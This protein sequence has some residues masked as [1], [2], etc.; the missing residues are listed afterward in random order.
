MKRIVQSLVFLVGFASI[1]GFNAFKKTSPT[2]AIPTVFAIK[3][4]LKVEIKVS[5]ELEAA[6]SISIASTIKGDQGKI[7]DL[8]VDGVY[9]QP[10]QVL[11][12]M[13]PT[14]F[15]DKVEKLLTQLKE[16][17]AYIAALEQT[18][19]WEKSQAEHKNRTAIYEIETATLELDKIIYGDGPQ[20]ISRLKGA[21]QKAWLKYD[22][23]NAYSNDLMELE[24]QGFLNTTEIRQAQK[25]LAEEREVYEMAKLQYESYIQHVY[26]MQV[27]K[28]ETSLKRAQVNEEETAK[29]G[30]YNVSKAS[31]LL[32]QAQQGFIDDSLQLMEAKKELAQTE[33]IAPAPGMVVHREDYRSGQRRK[34]RVGDILVK[35]QP[36]MDLPDL[37][38]MVIKTR[39]REVDLFKVGIGKKATIEVEAYPQLSLQGVIVSIGVLALNDSG[40]TSEEKYFEIRI[41]LDKSDPSLRPGMTTRAIIHAQEAH[42]ILTI[43]LHAVF[44][45]HKQAFCYVVL[46]NNVY[47]KRE[48]KIGMSNEQWVEVRDGLKEGDCVCLLNPFCH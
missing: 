11:V 7:I 43:P 15:E 32:N 16:Q 45:D 40:R 33:I 36:L 5:G 12:K 26:P 27:K 13:D 44:D 48:I 35:N 39:V 4:D 28:A 22:E 46:S 25:K 19:E 47:E 41:A 21:M 3:Q 34:P 38:S 6:H 24:V 9:V 2:T 17:E 10:G 18:L 23:L 14:P 31:A 37:S 30:I 42:E 8:I 1:L 29:L 20:E